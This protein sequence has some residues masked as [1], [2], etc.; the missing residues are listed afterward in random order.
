VQDHV[1]GAYPMATAIARL[2]M[3]AGHHQGQITA[4][5][6]VALQNSAATAVLAFGKSEVAAPH[7][8]IFL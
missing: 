2:F 7:L 1:A 4:D 8:D 3:S 6:L 5:V